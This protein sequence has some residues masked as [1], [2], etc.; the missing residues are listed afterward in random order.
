MAA[1]SPSSNKVST[2]RSSLHIGR[3]EDGMAMGEDKMPET[4]AMGGGSLVGF[5][6]LECWI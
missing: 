2:G 3:E 5:G 6:G 1:S 4:L